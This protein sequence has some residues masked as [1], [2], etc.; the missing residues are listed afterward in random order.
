MSVAAPPPMK[1]KQR[2]GDQIENGDPLMVLGQQP[3]ADGKADVE[4]R[5]RRRVVGDERQIVGNGG[6]SAGPPGAITL[7]SSTTVPAEQLHAHCGRHDQRR[8]HGPAG[9]WE[10]GQGS[11][12]SPAESRGRPHASRRCRRPERLDIR[13]QLHDLFLGKLAR[14]NWA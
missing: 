10:A 8:L 7:A 6:H 2:D 14:G 4:I 13:H 11:C 1:E 9:N 3:G 12:H 5:A